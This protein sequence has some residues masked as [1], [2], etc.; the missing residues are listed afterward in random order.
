MFGSGD[1]F[2]EVHPCH[3]P[4]VLLLAS[5]KLLCLIDESLLAEQTLTIRAFALLSIVECSRRIP[6]FPPLLIANSVPFGAYNKHF[7]LQ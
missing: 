5:S 7:R 4:F 2:F 6:P 1:F 3:F